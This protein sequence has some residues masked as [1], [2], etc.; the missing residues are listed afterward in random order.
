MRSITRMA[1][2]CRNCQIRDKCD[3]KRMEACAYYKE[4]F[5][6]SA[7]M[8]CAVEIAQPMAVKHDYRDVKIAENTTVT[9][10]LEVLKKQLS[11]EIYKSLGCGLNYGA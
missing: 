10:D 8:P 6:S 7:V 2:K 3:K 1:E 4:P 5:E 11:D 9:I